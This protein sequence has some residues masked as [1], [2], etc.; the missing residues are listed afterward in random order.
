MPS[1]NANYFGTKYMGLNYGLI[2]P[3]APPRLV[4]TPSRRAGFESLNTAPVTG[5]FS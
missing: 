3:P 2:L 1:Y 4:A 5:G